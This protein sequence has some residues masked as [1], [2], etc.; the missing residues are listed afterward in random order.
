[1]FAPRRL[2]QLLPAPAAADRVGR[3]LE[4]ERLLS[5][6]L[7]NLD[8]MVYRCRH[9]QHWTMEF[10]SEGCTDLTGY[11]PEDLVGNQRISYELLTHPEDRAPVRRTIEHALQQRTRYE[12][13][14]RIVRADGATRWVWERGAGS[15][16]ADGTLAALEGIVQD[17]SGRRQAEQSLREAERRYRSIFENAI[18]GIFQSTPADGYITVNPALARMYGYDS[19]EQLIAQLRDI[20]HQLYVEPNRR[21]DFIAAME[22]DGSVTNFESRVYRRDGT[23]IWI[24][25]N[26]RAVRDE[27]GV[28]LFYEGTV[29][30]I[31][32]RKLH[33][34]AMRHQATHDAL[35][36]LPNRSLLHEKLAHALEAAAHNG[37]LVAVAF[38]DLDQFKIVNDSLGH[39][40]GDELLKTMAQ[41]LQACLREHDVV[42]RQGGDEFV[43]MVTGALSEAEIG[44]IAR[45]LIAEVSRPCMIAGREVSVTCSIGITLSP[46]DGS[47]IEALLRNA[48]AAMYRAKELGRNN[49]QYFAAEM[50]ARVAGRLEMLTRLRRALEREEFELYYEPRYD[51]DARRIVGVEALI[52]WHQ[53]GAVVR[54]AEFIPLAEDTGLIVP[55][56]DWVLRQACAQ[57]R[58]WHDAGLRTVPVSVN[59]S[60]RQLSQGDI[61]A[62]VAQVLAASGLQ[63]QWLE[64]EI[65]ESMLMQDTERAIA[66]L[67][68]LR[69]KGVQISMDDFGTGYSSL[70]Y[71]KK[72]PV[73]RLK[74]DQAFLRDLPDDADARAMV[75]AIISLAHNLG[76]KVVA[77]GVETAAQ[78]EFLRG[79]DC[80]EVQG[81]YLARAMPAARFAE[82]LQEV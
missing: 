27:A 10:V 67:S 64:L 23:I 62:Q 3:P 39:H 20:D 24:S 80:D 28:L 16:T 72:L 5:T 57:T 11:R 78:F 6:L 47:D 15:F 25:E 49:Y 70:S 60:R 69:E 43:L 12:L 14:Y 18:E 45:R 56:G 71:L 50:N 42:A 7:S 2:S 61:A 54:P 35:T 22:R 48:D 13:E 4:R 29:E 19:P 65:T 34:S 82:L 30:T 81:W 63:P 55:I 37:S 46:A 21:A 33:D 68:R 9:D 1:M 73:Q 58:R 79:A 53:D 8:G 52:R 41:R 38:I 59:L 44:R 51:F 36:G 17:I 74:I 32:E 31:T 26:A 66:L 40:M 77:E 75:K 76:L